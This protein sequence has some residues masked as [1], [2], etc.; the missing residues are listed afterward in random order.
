MKNP[1]FEKFNSAMDAILRADPKAV[2]EAMETEARAHAEEREAKGEHKRGRKPS[3]G[4]PCNLVF[5]GARCKKQIEDLIV[6]TKAGFLEG[7]THKPINE[8]FGLFLNFL[9]V[10]MVPAVRTGDLNEFVLR[11]SLGAP[12]QDFCAALRARDSARAVRVLDDL[13]NKTC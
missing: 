12:F 8:L 13:R 1:D 5:D 11:V 7:V 10:D 2:K 6:L 3:S 9:I 4:Q